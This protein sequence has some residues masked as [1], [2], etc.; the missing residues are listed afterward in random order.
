MLAIC[1]VLPSEHT[2]QELIVF[3]EVLLSDGES[4]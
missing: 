3:L 2:A 4:S 1:C